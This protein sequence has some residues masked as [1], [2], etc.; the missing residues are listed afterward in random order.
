MAIYILTI[1]YNP[2]SDECESISEQLIQDEPCIYV[3]DLD[4]SDYWDEDSRKL[5]GEMYDVGVT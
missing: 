1:E 4:I 2:D 5:M 3:D